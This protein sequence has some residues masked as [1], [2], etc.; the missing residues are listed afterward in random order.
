MAEVEKNQ[1]AVIGDKD[2][3]LGFKSIGFDTYEVTKTTEQ[4]IK[5]F[6]IAILRKN[7]K[8]VYITENYFIVCEKDID[9]FLKNKAYPIVTV[10][11]TTASDKDIAFES[12]KK[13][14]E[15]ALGGSFF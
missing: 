12:M 10:I 5:Q 6:V 2:S 7:Y 9:E 4:E 14:V 13:L 11:P 15:K 1:I 8:I 3:I